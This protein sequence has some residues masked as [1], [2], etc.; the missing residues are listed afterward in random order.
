MSDW[1]DTGDRIFFDENHYVVE[2]LNLLTTT[3]FIYGQIIYIPNH[4][5]AQKTILN[6]RRSKDMADYVVLKVG[7]ISN[8]PLE[9]FLNVVRFFYKRFPIFI[10]LSDHQ[11]SLIGSS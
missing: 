10:I 1:A 5:M 9:C 7:S 8:F 11:I 3:L 2:E 4:M 6:A